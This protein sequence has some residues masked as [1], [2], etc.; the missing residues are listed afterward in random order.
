MSENEQAWI[1]AV[2][3]AE[4][5]RCGEASPL[6]LVESAIERVVRADSELGF[7]VS[8]MFEEAITTAKGVIGKGPLAGVPMLLK[9]NLATAQGVPYSAG[10]RFLGDFEALH[11]SEL[12]ARYRR[13]G[14]IP[15]GTSTTS[16]FGLLSTAESARY[17]P[18]RNPWNLA[19]TTGGSSGGSAAA[20]A[21]GCVSIGHGNDAGGSIRIPASCCGLFGLKPTRARNPL[22]PDFGD[23]AGGIWAE[24]VMTRSVR[25]SAAALDA[26]TGPMLGDPYMAPAFSRRYISEVGSNPGR[27]KIAFTDVA[28]TGVNVE[29]EPR[30]AVRSAA[31]LCESLGHEVVEAALPV[32]AKALEEAFLVVFS[33]GAGWYLKLWEQQLSRVASRGEIEPYTRGLAE[34]GCSHSAVDFLSAVQEMQMASRQIARFHR[35]HHL[36]LCPTLAAAPVPL[37]FFESTEEDPM[38]PLRADTAFAAFTWIANATG[39]PSMSVPLHWSADGLPIGV[40]FTAPFGREDLLFRFGSQLEQAQPW[41]ERRPPFGTRERD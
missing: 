13:S 16:E 4:L 5:V 18:C 32:D 10:S 41:A 12:V 36:S 7:L 14:L 26:S 6:E 23:I 25:D 31:A 35:E 37:G 9:D 29:A 3:Q 28:P 30:V 24:H 39:Q 2:G 38:R 27:L 22:G 21:A 33:S 19:R 11:D 8:P 34:L 15:I 17:G 40:Q 20:V 1:D